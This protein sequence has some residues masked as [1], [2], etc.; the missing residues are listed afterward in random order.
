MISHFASKRNA[1]APRPTASAPSPAACN[2]PPRYTFLNTERWSVFRKPAGILISERLA[3]EHE[4]DAP[5]DLLVLDDQ[6]LAALA[7]RAAAGGIVAAAGH[8]ARRVLLE[9]AAFL[10]R[11]GIADALESGGEIGHQLVRA[12][13]KDHAP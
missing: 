8:G 5:R 7:F 12:G 13:E 4:R 9:L 11:S 3:D 1:G 6:D 10:Q 2:D